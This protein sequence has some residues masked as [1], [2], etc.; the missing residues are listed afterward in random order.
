MT[1]QEKLQQMISES[2]NIVFL[3]EQV[4]PPK[5]ASRIFGV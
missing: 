1:P 2:N 4:F 5:V 3:A